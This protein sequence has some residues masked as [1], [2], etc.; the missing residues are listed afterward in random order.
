MLT[1]GIIALS[2]VKREQG[3]VSQQVIIDEATYVLNNAD[4]YPSMLMFAC[5]VQSKPKNIPNQS[6]W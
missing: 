5:Y 2:K 1:T 4:P 3:K 6:F